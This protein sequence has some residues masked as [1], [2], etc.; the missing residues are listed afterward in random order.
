[1]LHKV[2]GVCR[3]ALAM[4]VLSAVTAQGQLLGHLS[5]ASVEEVGA[6][7][8]GGYLGLTGDFVSITGQFR[9]GIANS[10]D[11]GVKAAFVDFA[12]GGGSSVAFNTDAKIQLLDVYLQ[13]PVDLAIGPDLSYFRAH[14]VT[15]WYF[16][17]FLVLSKEFTMDNGKPLSPYTRLGVRMHRSESDLGQA[18]DL[19][20][21][22]A[23]G[24]EYGV[25]GYTQIYGEVVI[26]DTGTGV[27]VGAGY[28]LP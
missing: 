12:D 10:F 20:M 17:G 23:G 27:Y 26:E 18:D 11:L 4:V 2:L 22:F 5:T 19:D 21:G 13:D 24:L 3:W 8:V 16:G 15:H 9:Y 28:Q 7:K 6:K 25:S 1:M 14:D